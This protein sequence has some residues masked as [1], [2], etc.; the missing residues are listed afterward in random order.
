MYLRSL[1]FCVLLI[2][3][4][5]FAFDI[6]I[7]GDVQDTRH[8]GFRQIHRCSRRGSLRMNS[9]TCSASTTMFR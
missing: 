4:R 8:A 6:A 9:G 3:G 7:Y 1:I 5:S 2:G